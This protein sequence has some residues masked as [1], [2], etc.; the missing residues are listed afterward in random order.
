MDEKLTKIPQVQ[1]LT[2]CYTI[3]INP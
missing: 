3:L 1:V 2:N